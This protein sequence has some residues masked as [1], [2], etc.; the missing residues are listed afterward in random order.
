MVTTKMMKV[1]RS[2]LRRQSW[3]EQ[4]PECI[5]L[6]FYIILIAWAIAHHEPWADEAQAWQ[7]A[8]NVPLL[9]L[10]RHSLRYEGH[11]GLWYIVIA[12]LSKL[13]VDYRGLH[14]FCGVIGAISA[15]L[16]MFRSPFPRY[17]RLSLPFTFFL[18]FQYVVVAR[19]YVLAPLL[20][21]CLALAWRRSIL[22]AALLLGLL[23]NVSMHC[24]AI[25][26]GFVLVYA[27]EL[28]RG[29]SVATRRQIYKA[30]A[31]TGTLCL[32]AIVTVAP[33]PKDIVLPFQ[34]GIP[35]SIQRFLAPVR[36]LVSLC[37][38]VIQPG[39]LAIPLWLLILRQF[40]RTKLLLYLLPTATLALLCGYVF[41]FWHAGLIVPT[42]ITIC[43]I[44]WPQITRTTQGWR[45]I[46]IYI[47]LVIVV[48]EAW[49]V[50]AVYHH[51]Y[52]P[53][54]ETARFLAPYVEAGDTMAVTYVKRDDVNAFH[55]VGLYPYFDHPLFI[56]EPRPYWLW[57][58]HEHTFNEFDRAMDSHPELVVAMYFDIYHRFNPS[59]DLTG[60][61]VARIQ[62]DGYR[63]TN[64]FCAEKPEGFRDREETCFLIFQRPK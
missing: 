36:M 32:L 56:N 11:P 41:T 51:R 20:L 14:W 45:P 10:F 26:A 58:T 55:S 34:V 8:R 6:T 61:R 2:K 59:K 43:W 30:A 49:T 63:L 54:I 13:R 33:H 39:I 62:K 42:A 16:L 7:L 27:M 57:S 35:V 9:E 5:A 29:I 25:S 40:K 47:A 23:A 12:C 1:P 44:A 22:L 19:S 38:G 46:L 60:P 53:D 64:T 48:Q 37:Q 4:W 3:I 31:I 52:S 28:R 17:V 24:L 15:A 18:A 50:R 21:F